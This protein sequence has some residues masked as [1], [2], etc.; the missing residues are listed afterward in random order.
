VART[1]ENASSPVESLTGSLL[2][3]WRIGD[4]YRLLITL[5]IAAS[6]RRPASTSDPRVNGSPRSWTMGHGTAREPSPVRK[7]RRRRTL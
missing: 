3:T 6:A 4:R 2:A 7:R 5:A 1:A